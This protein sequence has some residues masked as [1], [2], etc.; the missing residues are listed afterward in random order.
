MVTISST[1]S[2]HAHDTTDGIHVVST[3]VPV[4]STLHWLKKGWI[5]IA[6]APVASLFYGLTTTLFIAISMLLAID[7]PFL[8]MAIGTSFI[9]IAPFLATGLYDIAYRLE[10]GESPSLTHSLVSWK[11]NIGNFGLYVASLGVIISAWTIVT[12]LMAALFKSQSLLIVDPDAG[13][14]S[15]LMTDAGI[16]FMIAFA[17]I[18]TLVAT[19][20]FAISVVSI[21][22]LIDK[23]KLDAVNAMIISYQVT[24]EN[25]GVMAVWAIIIGVLV[26]LGIA[27][28]GVLM[29]IIMPLLSYASWHAY[30]DLIKFADDAKA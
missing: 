25:K 16:N 4:I 28:F 18:G 8:M 27:T 17:L 29:V 19:F 9:M 3:E 14:I 23:H 2:N 24:M 10:R 20:V 22:L 6:H 12:P 15:F 7:L 30:R 21:P 1:S 26:S 11:D 5:D 13:F